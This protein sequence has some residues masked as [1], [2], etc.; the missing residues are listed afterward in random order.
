MKPTL[1][2]DELSVDPPSMMTKAFDKPPV[3]LIVWPCA[4][5]TALIELMLLQTSG[6]LR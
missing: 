5:L 4:R 1:T 6:G 2:S 3:Q